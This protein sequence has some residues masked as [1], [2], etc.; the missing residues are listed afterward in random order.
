MEQGGSTQGC[1]L[2]GMIILKKCQSQ[3]LKQIHEGHVGTVKMKMLA[4][5]HFWWP[6]LDE[7]VEK[8][9]KNCSGCLETCHMSFPSPNPSLGVANKTL[10]ENTRGQRRTIGRAP[11]LVV[12]DAHAKWP[13]VFC[14]KSQTS[15]QTIEY[16]RIVFSRFGLPLK[17]ANEFT[18]FMA[19]NGVKHATSAPF[20]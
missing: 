11:F 20:H 14:T 3:V 18:Q 19:V 12:I 8:M 15:A 17:L 2:W 16:F 7:Q 9:T 5:S 4:C 10:T 13:E 6:R 1:L